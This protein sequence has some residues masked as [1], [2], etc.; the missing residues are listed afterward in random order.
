MFTL[1]QEQAINM[2]NIAKNKG[3][4]QFN[5]ALVGMLMRNKCII[6]SPD[7]SI[8]SHNKMHLL[9][10]NAMKNVV[11]YSFNVS[12]LPLQKVQPRTYTI[13]TVDAQVKIFRFNI[14]V[15]FVS[16]T[17]A[18][19]LSNRCGIIKFSPEHIRVFAPYDL[20]QIKSAQQ[21]KRIANL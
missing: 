21:V 2:V 20:W 13:P 15:E 12:K 18:H 17:Y 8:I 7:G 1:T 5:Q 9:F 16:D 4:N 6:M 11:I 10:D 3:L 19:A 14:I